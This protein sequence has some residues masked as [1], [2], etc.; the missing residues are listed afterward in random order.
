[1]SYV[2]RVNTIIQGMKRHTYGCMV[3][4][5]EAGASDRTLVNA[6]FIV[7]PELVPPSGLFST[8]NVCCPLMR[9][10]FVYKT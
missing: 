1:M 5:D 8:R 9:S 6:M 10:D 3:C 2:I 7:D 4:V